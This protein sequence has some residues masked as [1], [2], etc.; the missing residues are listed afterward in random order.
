[1][2]RVNFTMKRVRGLPNRT[3]FLERLLRVAQRGILWCAL[4]VLSSPTGIVEK[5]EAAA[6][7]LQRETLTARGDQ[8]RS[9]GFL[10][11]LTDVFRGVYVRTMPFDHDRRFVL[12]GKFAAP[13]LRSVISVE[14]MPLQLDLNCFVFT[15]H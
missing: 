4:F 15:A 13:A 1:M 7:A 2:Q 5:V 9:F 8:L 10:A 3:V 12:L 11:D 6:A 14:L